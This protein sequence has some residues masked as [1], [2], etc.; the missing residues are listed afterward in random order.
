MDG[1]AI[2]NSKAICLHTVQ[3]T[4][5]SKPYRQNHHMPTN[6]RFVSLERSLAVVK[7][8]Q[9]CCLSQ[10]W[11]HV[12]ERR[13]FEDIGLSTTTGTQ[14]ACKAIEFGEITQNNGY[15]LVQ[16]HPR[17][18]MSVPIEAHMQ[19]HRLNCNLLCLTMRISRQKSINSVC[20]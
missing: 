20:T 11:L 10:F 13:Y 17:S 9:D 8:P 5:G 19:L 16:R 6:G 4:T 18:P 14:S 2:I 3:R 12:T 1:A 7:R 15:Y